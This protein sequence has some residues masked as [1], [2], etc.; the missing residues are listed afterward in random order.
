MTPFFQ[1]DCSQC[2][3]VGSGTYNGEKV[4]VW[5]SCNPSPASAHILRFGI[6]GNYIK[7][8]I[9]HTKVVYNNELTEV[10]QDCV[11]AIKFLLNDARQERQSLQTR[12]SS[13]NNTIAT[14][15]Q[16]LEYWSQPRANTGG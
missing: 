13:V 2:Q 9:T 10:Q 5:K 7:T 16:K 4:D 8:N 11:E 14:L 6:N 3:Y 12:L 15:E 1:H